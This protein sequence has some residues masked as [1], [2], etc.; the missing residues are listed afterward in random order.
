MDTPTPELDHGDGSGHP[1]EDGDGDRRPDPDWRLV[2]TL[3]F[4]FSFGAV[5]AVRFAQALVRVLT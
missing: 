4:G 5:T 2:A 3:A 1:P